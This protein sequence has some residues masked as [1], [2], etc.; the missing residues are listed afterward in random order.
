MLTIRFIS[1]GFD[2]TVTVAT[3]GGR[4]PTLL[5]IAKQHGVPVL[6]N[7]ESGACGACLVSVTD[8]SPDARGLA[9]PGDQERLFLAATDNLHAEIAADTPHYRL[10]CVAT[11][12]D[13]SIVVR[14]S[15]RVRFF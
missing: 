15:N 11:L 7:C 10:A 1:R 5:A 4:R 14:F 13:G 12:G 9:P 6:F 3:S 8:P 2:K